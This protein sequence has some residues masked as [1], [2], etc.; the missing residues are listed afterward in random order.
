MS[1]DRLETV[2]E[3]LRAF[4]AERDWQQFHDPKNLAMAVVS[5]AGEMAAEYRWIPNAEADVWSR[6]PENR[7]RVAREAADVGIAL[8]LFF[9]RI[10]V[11]FL[12]AVGAKIE[13]NRRNYPVET[14]KGRS[15]RSEGGG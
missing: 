2:R 10:G 14:S 3:S 6:E 11:D 7:S 15:E 4:V 5:E 8:L 9:D 1:G 12:E 13:V